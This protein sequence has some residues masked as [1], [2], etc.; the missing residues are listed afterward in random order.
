MKAGHNRSLGQST[1][2]SDI[3]I[4]E[5]KVVSIWTRW[6]RM[7]QR[8]LSSHTALKWKVGLLKQGG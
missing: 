1:R 8:I 4:M 6:L 3:I 5:R 7:G 2:R